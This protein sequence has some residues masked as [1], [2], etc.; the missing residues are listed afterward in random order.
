MTSILEVPV[1]QNPDTQGK[2]CT[3]RSF[4]EIRV[5]HAAVEPCCALVVFLVLVCKVWILSSLQTKPAKR[6]EWLPCSQVSKRQRDSLPSLFQHVLICTILY[7]SLR[8][9]KRTPRQF[10]RAPSKQGQV[11]HPFARVREGCVT[12]CHVT[13]VVCRVV[14]SGEQRHRT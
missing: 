8:H 14:S 4:I 6:G 10:P 12:S 13:A 9:P 7:P 11:R 5:V 3:W 1:A 2:V